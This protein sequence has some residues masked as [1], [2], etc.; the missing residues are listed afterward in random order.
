MPLIKLSST[1]ASTFS[2]RTVEISKVEM[3][4]KRFGLSEKCKP[5]HDASLILSKG[6]AEV[7][8]WPLQTALVASSN[9]SLLQL[10]QIFSR[11]LSTSVFGMQGSEKYTCCAVWTV[12]S[13][14]F[15]LK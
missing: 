12:T 15:Y 4:Y 1:A 2:I 5:V 11:R 14:I 6:N 3:F 8:S 7:V 13:R 9:S 10:L